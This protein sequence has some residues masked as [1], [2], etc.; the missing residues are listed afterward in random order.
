MAAPAPLR[1]ALVTL[2]RPRVIRYRNSAMATCYGGQDAELQ[3][4]ETAVASW[5]QETMAAGWS[6]GGR[7]EEDDADRSMIV[8]C[9][10]LPAQVMLGTAAVPGQAPAPRPTRRES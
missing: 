7:S 9:T 3:R 8:R 6:I 1:H 2:Y 10:A 5:C 4:G